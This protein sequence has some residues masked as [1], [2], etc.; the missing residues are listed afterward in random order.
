MPPARG[1]P[2]ATNHGVGIARNEVTSAATT[3]PRARS[4]ATIPRT[5]VLAT[6]RRRSVA[7]SAAADRS[8][9]SATAVAPGARATSSATAPTMRIRPPS[10]EP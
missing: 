1:D 9:A 4:T 10:G 2:I 7:S 6:C 8:Q 5:T 3:G